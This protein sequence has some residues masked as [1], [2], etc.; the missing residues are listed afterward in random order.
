MLLD[1]AG[2]GREQMSDVAERIV[3]IVTKHI[4]GDHDRVTPEANFLADLGA[5]SLDVVELVMAIE[6]DF[7]IE[8]PDADAEKIMTVQDAVHYV[9]S[10]R[11]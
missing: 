5:D 10:A 1:F 11:G 6:E 2:R 8:I 4:G 3:K 9:R 7:G